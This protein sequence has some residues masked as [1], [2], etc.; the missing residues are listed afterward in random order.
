LAEETREK[1]MTKPAKDERMPEALETF[2]AAARNNGK[3]PDDL[4]LTATPETAPKPGD[5]AA[6][7]KDAADM[8]NAAATSDA[9]KKDEAIARRVKADKRAG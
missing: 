6:E 5:L 2:A 7:E 1:T 8:L 9:R 4:G 3:K